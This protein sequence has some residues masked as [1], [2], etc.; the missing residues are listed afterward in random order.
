MPQDVEPFTRL[1]QDRF[2]LHRIAVFIRAERV[3]QIDFA[4]VNPRRQ[5][6]LGHVAI[7][8]LQSFRDRERRWHLCAGTVV[9]LYVNLAHLP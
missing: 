9:N 3:R 7:Q 5:G 6:L 2:D 8:L 1:R 4:A